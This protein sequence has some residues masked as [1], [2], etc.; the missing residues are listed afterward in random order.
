[1][2]WSPDSTQIASGSYDNTVKLWNAGTFECQSTLT[3]DSSV[4]SVAFS[5][6]GSKIA[7]AHWNKI[8]LFDAQTQAQAKLGSPLNVD[9][10]VLC[11]SYSPSGDTLAV[12]C[13]IGKIL[14][15]DAVTVVVKRSFSG[16]S[17]YVRAV[18][19]NPDGTMLASGS[20]DKTVKLWDAQTGQVQSTLNGHM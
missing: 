10:F 1:M 4:Y 9:S 17:D 12:G 11:I 5:P 7:V 3:V 6:D 14:L 8:Q 15:L 19:W 16:H 18:T 13:N 2:A 20:D